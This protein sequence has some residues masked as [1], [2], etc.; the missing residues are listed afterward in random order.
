MIAGTYQ[1]TQAEDT[2][3]SSIIVTVSAT[4]GDRGETVTYS[5]VTTVDEFKIEPSSGGIILV[6]ELDRE[7]TDIYELVVQAT[8]GMNVAT[9]TVSITV[10]DVN[11]HTPTFSPASYRQVIS[12]V[13]FKS[14]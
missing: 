10:I 9:A 14:I 7:S 12:I 1:V 13:P 5:L 4:D 11:D 2:A 6:A 8:D 3:L